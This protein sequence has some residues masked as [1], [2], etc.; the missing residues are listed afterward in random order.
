M[1]KASACTTFVELA[2]PSHMAKEMNVGVYHTR[3]WMQK[4]MIH[5]DH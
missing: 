4:A 2:K 5:W 1:E 3:A